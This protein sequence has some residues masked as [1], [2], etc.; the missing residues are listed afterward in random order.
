MVD[1][2]T[3]GSGPNASSLLWAQFIAASLQHPTQGQQM[4]QQHN[5]AT[6]SSFNIELKWTGQPI[7][8]RHFE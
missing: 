1:N 7:L 2:P 4:Q 5:V 8:C 6:W 3:P